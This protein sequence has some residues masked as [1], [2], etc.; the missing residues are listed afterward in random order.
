VVA[1]E[2]ILSGSLALVIVAGLLAAWLGDWQALAILA[3]AVGIAA[4]AGKL[5]FDSIVQRDAPDAVQGRNFARFETRFQLV[6]VLAAAVPVIIP[7][8]TVIGVLIIAAG[9]GVALVTYVG[10]L[11]ATAH[12]K[13]AS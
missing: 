2:K 3:G 4:G 6:W 10:G 13:P 8:P 9:A 12:T 1:E 11:S 5:A 7:I